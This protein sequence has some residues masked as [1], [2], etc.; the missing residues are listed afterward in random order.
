MSD[1]NLGAVTEC[2]NTSPCFQTTATFPHFRIELCV[3]MSS[4]LKQVLW[5]SLQI[6]HSLTGWL[7]TSYFFSWILRFP[8]ILAWRKSLY[9]CRPLETLWPRSRKIIHGCT[10]HGCRCHHSV[11]I[12]VCLAYRNFTSEEPLLCLLCRAAIYDIPLLV[13]F[14][15]TR[16]HWAKRTITNL[17]VHRWNWLTRWVDKT[18]DSKEIWKDNCYRIRMVTDI[19]G[20]IK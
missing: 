2:Y 4:P 14:K 15:A 9:S 8:H 17:G 6:S 11:D 20:D 3:S 12:Y 1:F 19:F 18:E 13:F 10:A 16:P 7:W 5:L